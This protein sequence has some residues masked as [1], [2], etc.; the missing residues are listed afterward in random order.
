M[1]KIAPI[2]LL[3]SV[4]LFFAKC[5]NSRHSTEKKLFGKKWILTA[6]NGKQITQIEGKIAQLSFTAADSKVVGNTGCNNL[7]G[8]FT[9]NGD[10]GISL[11]KMATTRMAC[12]GENIENIFWPL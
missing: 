9:L 12:A 4:C 11:G 5:S 7:S 8:T 2:L 6:I 10:R 3:I 1:K